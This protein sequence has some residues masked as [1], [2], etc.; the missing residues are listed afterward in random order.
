MLT[1]QA[2]QLYCSEMHS[3]N[4]ENMFI[5]IVVANMGAR[6]LPDMYA[7]GLRAYT[8]FACKLLILQI[9]KSKL[10]YITKGFLF[11]DTS[12]LYAHLPPREC[13]VLVSS[14]QSA[15]HF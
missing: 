5:V 7:R 15:I 14:S 2:E 4:I 8:R 10:P 12:F 9:H 6:D 13:T 11:S 1:T 3:K